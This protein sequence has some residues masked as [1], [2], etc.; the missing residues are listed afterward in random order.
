MLRKALTITALLAL[1]AAVPAVASAGSGNED[2]GFG[3]QIETQSQTEIQLQNQ[4]QL[5]IDPAQCTGDGFGFGHGYG[6][7]DGSE[8]APRPQDGTGFGA[9]ARRADGT[10]QGGAGPMDGT[11]PYHEEGAP[12]APRDGTGLRAGRTI[13]DQ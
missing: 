13:S 8:D 7:V 1:V 3:R 2:A 10:W 12:I 6:L 9:Q 11:G 5:Q 4:E